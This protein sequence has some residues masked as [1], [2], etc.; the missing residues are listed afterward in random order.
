MKTSVGYINIISAYAP[1]LTSTP[2]AKDQFY[3]ALEDV[4]SCIPKSDILAGRL[5]RTHWGRPASMAHLPRPPWHRQ[6]E[7][8]RTETAR[9]LLPSQPLHHQLYFAGKDRHKVSW[10]HPRSRHWH[11]LDLVITRR[12]DL[13]TVLHTRSYHSA[14]C[15]TDHSL[16]ASKV[17]LKPRRIHHAKTKGRPRLNTCGTY[18]PGKVKC[19]ADKFNEG[20]A[21]ETTS[22]DPD[23]AVAFWDLLRD[24]IY[25]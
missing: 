14:D 6:V 12:V 5:Q 8:E 7:R 11:Q 2:E 4:L 9:T 16:V 15:D 3:E 19:F 10:R 22:N 20:I 13:S 18:D 25:D 1:T 21:A 24:T 23:N 17:R